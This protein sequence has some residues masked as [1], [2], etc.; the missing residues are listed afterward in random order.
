MGSLPT[1]DL[2]QEGVFFTLGTIGTIGQL[3]FTRSEF[4]AQCSIFNLPLE[5]ARFYK[6]ERLKECSMLERGFSNRWFFSQK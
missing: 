4:N 5:L 2:N 1:R 6:A 3:F